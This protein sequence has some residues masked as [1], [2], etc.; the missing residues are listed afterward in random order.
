MNRNVIRYSEAFK[1]QVVSELE[2]GRFRSHLE[3]SQTYGIRGS[4][5]VRRWLKEYGKNHLLNRV[6]RIESVNEKD[7][8]RALE[9]EISQLKN[10]VA[11]SKLQE[12]IHKTTFEVVCQ[13]Y[14]LGSPSEVKKKL[15]AKL[16]K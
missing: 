10:A 13:E 4:A 12:L 11:D 6:V 16:Q 14:G 8:I 1:L 9:K 2:S 5:T 7:Q 3:A 15:D